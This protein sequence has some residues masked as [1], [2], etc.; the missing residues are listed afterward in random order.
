MTLRIGSLEIVAALALFVFLMAR[1]QPALVAARAQTQRLQLELAVHDSPGAPGEPR[2]VTL[3]LDDDQPAA[4]IG[5][6]SAAQVGLLDPEV[7]R[8]HAQL[9]IARGVVYL[10][11]LGSVNGTFLNGNR[12][13]NEGIE[14]RA[15]DD[16]D[17]GNT[18]ITVTEMAP[19]DQWT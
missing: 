5:R 2:A 12:L 15:G 16:I 14:V 3:R 4:L 1:W 7:S 10:N 11:D 6:S 8:R 13:R 9:Q 19:V 17:V 18:R